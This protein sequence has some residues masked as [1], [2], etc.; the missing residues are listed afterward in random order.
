[1]CLSSNIAKNEQISCDFDSPS[2]NS[3]KLAK[4]EGKNGQTFGAFTTVEVVNDLKVRQNRSQGSKFAFK[5][6]LQTDGRLPNELAFW[7]TW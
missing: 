2:T 4:I 7:Y 5:V 3:G 6:R 1:L